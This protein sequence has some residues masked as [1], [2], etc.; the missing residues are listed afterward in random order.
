MHWS[1]YLGGA[2]LRREASRRI[3]GVAIVGTLL[4]LGTAL[5]QNWPARPTVAML[6]VVQA[7]QIIARIYL[8]H[9]AVVSVVVA[10]AGLALVRKREALW[11]VPWEN[12][13]AATKDGCDVCIATNDG[14]LVR[15]GMDAGDA[16]DVAL[17]TIRTAVARHRTRA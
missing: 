14:A 9:E 2:A 16:Q 10:D 3:T 1:G 17:L 12:V 4:V 6:L 5:L 13:C 7:S 8:A 11:F 15:V